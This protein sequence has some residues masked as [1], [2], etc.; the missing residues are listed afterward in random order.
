MTSQTIVWSVPLPV[1]TDAEL[2]RVFHRS[3]GNGHLTD[4]SVTGD[5]VDSFPNVRSMIEPDVRFFNPAPDTLPRNILPLFVIVLDLSYFGMLGER[6]LM[7][8]P[9]CPNIGNGSYRPTR[10]S[11]V[12]IHALQLNLLD[13]DAMNECDGL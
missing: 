8:G 10:G 3:R 5:A 9:A 1:T 11:D 12:T 2:H 13:V 7:T 4:V 6:S